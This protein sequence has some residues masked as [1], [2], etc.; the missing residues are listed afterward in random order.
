MRCALGIYNDFKKRMIMETINSQILYDAISIDEDGNYCFCKTAKKPFLQVLKDIFMNRLLIAYPILIAAYVFWFTIAYWVTGESLTSHAFSI[1]LFPLLLLPFFQV[2]YYFE[3]HQNV[4]IHKGTIVLLF[5]SGKQ[6]E[7]T[8]KC[9]GTNHKRIKVLDLVSEESGNAIYDYFA[10]EKGEIITGRNGMGK[11]SR[12]LFK[13]SFYSGCVLM[14]A[15]SILAISRVLT[16]WPLWAVL[17]VP[18]AIITIISFVKM[19]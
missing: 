1:A 15:T 11:E 16:P 19:R 6:C 17:L 10:K 13:I 8:Y 7:I 9:K 14:V 3:W 18:T 12:R 5:F 4:T 2:F